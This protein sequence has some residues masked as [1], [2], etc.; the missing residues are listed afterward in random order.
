MPQ[1]LVEIEISTLASYSVNA[2][3]RADAE[4]V[5]L[6][7]YEVLDCVEEHDNVKVVSVVEVPN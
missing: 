3:S 1:F 7:T 5:V 2:D 4:C 6:D